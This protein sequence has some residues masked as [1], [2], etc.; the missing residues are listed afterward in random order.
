MAS[1]HHLNY[2]TLFLLSLL[3]LSFPSLY[4]L[5][6]PIC[7]HRDLVSRNRRLKEI[8][9]RVKKMRHVKRG[10]NLIED[11]WAKKDDFQQI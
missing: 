1:D 5:S 10:K 9:A 8:P 7:F 6:L 11:I 4:S 3:F 2:T